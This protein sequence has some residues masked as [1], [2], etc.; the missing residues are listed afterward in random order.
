[1]RYGA[2]LSV[3]LALFCV[4]FTSRILGVP[5]ASPWNLPSRNCGIP[6]SGRL[7]SLPQVVGWRPFVAMKSGPGSNGVATAAKSRPVP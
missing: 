3:I 4:I 2:L 5:E 6:S 1:M 7:P